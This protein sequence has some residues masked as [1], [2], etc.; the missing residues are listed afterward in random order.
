MI[1]LEKMH[2]NESKQQNQP[3]TPGRGQ[4]PMKEATTNAVWFDWDRTLV[5][6][7]GD[8]AGHERLAALFQ[9]EGLR[10]TPAQMAA[11]I[12]RYRADVAQQK[13][14]FLGDPPQGQQDIMT[15]YAHLLHNLGFKRV[16]KAL[17]ERLYS[18][19]ALL[20]TILYGDALPVLA[21]LQA[22]GIALGIISNHSITVRPVMERMVG[23]FVAPEHIVISQELGVTKPSP[24][25]FAEAIERMA[26]SAAHS[27]YV[28]DNLEVDAVGAVQHGG[29]ARGF[30]LDR[31]RVSMAAGEK[32][33]F[34]HQVTRITNLWQ[35]LDWL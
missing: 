4:R 6:V 12:A 21:A 3:Q 1:S 9:R 8:V 2:T 7:V 35:I 32:R 11:A 31:S 34:P 20:P 23:E 27:F 18:G 14:P 15:Y 28:G 33:P 25:I 30:W 10:F 17:L 16:D 5:R 24:Y 19:Y 26:I 22:R 29:F 13:L